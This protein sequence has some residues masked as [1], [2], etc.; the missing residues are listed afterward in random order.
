MKKLNEVELLRAIK[1]IN[2]VSVKD[3]I[4]S[5]NRDNHS[6]GLRSWTKIEVLCKSFGYSWR[7]VDS[8]EAKEAQREE[9]KRITKEERREQKAEKKFKI[10]LPKMNFK[11]L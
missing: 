4:I 7:F 1:K 9:R 6:V 3:N 11:K 5:I 8:H 2:G 10:K